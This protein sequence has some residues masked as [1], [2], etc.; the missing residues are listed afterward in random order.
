MSYELSVLADRPMAYWK[1]DGTSASGNLNWEQDINQLNRPLVDE[2]LAGGTSNPFTYGGGYGDTSNNVAYTQTST[3]VSGASASLL[4]RA[5]DLYDG[6]TYVIGRNEWFAKNP[7]NI[8]KGDQ[9][10]SSFS[11]EFW[12]SFNNMFQGSG[13][14]YNN[15]FD[16]NLKSNMTALEIISFTSL[17]DPHS[18]TQVNGTRLGSIYYDYTSNTFRF[19]VA[20]TDFNYFE[21]RDDA[22]FVV[23]NLNTP[24]H[25]VVTYDNGVLGITV[26]GE[27]GVAGKADISGCRTLSQWNSSGI[28]SAYKQRFF[29]GLI[30]I[31]NNLQ[32]YSYSYG[33]YVLAHLA[34]YD[35]VLPLDSIRRHIVWASHNDKPSIAP[36][37]IGT[38]M[39][40]TT[41]KA[42]NVLHHEN[43]MGSNF[44]DNYKIFNLN[45]DP[46]LGLT[47]KKIKSF[48]VNPSSDLS[49]SVYFSPP[50]QTVDHW[51]SPKDMHDTLYAN[52]N[53]SQGMKVSGYGSVVLDEFGSLISNKSPITI[54]CEVYPYSPA[55][56]NFL[57]AFTESISGN[58]IYAK[59]QSTGVYI[60]SY[61]YE[62]DTHTTLISSLFSVATA[63]AT[64]SPYDIGVSFGN[65]AVC[66]FVDGSSSSASTERIIINQS[67]MIEVGN[68]LQLSSGSANTYIRN[69]GFSNILYTDF[70][71]YNFGE[72]IM[73][74]ARFY[75]DLSISQIGYWIKRIPLASFGNRMVGSKVAWDGMDNCR[76]EYSDDDGYSWSILQKNSSIFY[77]VSYNYL[78]Y[79]YLLKVTIPYEYELGLVNQSFNNLEISFYENMGFST[80][81]H[82]YE[83][84]PKNDNILKPTFIVQR[85]SDQMFY[86]K[87]NFGIKFE[88]LG[89]IPIVNAGNEVTSY[90]S[91]I[92]SSSINAAYGIDFWVKFYSAPNAGSRILDSEPSTISPAV[93]LS[94]TTN[95]YDYS[96]GNYERF[97]SLDGFDNNINSV[98]INGQSVAPSGWTPRVNE[99]YHVTLDFGA[100]YTGSAL[101]LNGASVHS[102]ATYGYINMWNVPVSSSAAQI[103]YQSFIGNNITSIEDDATNLLMANPFS[104]STVS[105]AAFQI[106]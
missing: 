6:G 18:A 58:L 7:Y 55:T 31:R 87:N 14:D 65:G 56:P 61:S 104:A 103:R 13:Y 102:H 45:I 67:T 32:Y 33:S 39:F 62:T 98:Y 59:I 19:Q 72:N 71:G 92:A 85:N 100:A 82:K 29:D 53:I 66:L 57:W 38:S 79:D 30:W 17:N 47:G 16:V 46:D 24:Y 25:I 89:W 51:F 93:W 3:L 99:Y 63:S 52:S 81:D 27:A 41:E 9:A 90:A 75:Q 64:T 2:N 73:F 86:R 36:R 106:G 78:N 44:K 23:R 68:V 77:H 83:L 70:S 12:F 80:D 54:T 95:L 105:T 10:H 48:V 34:L 50:T 37:L 35:Y 91:I 22:Y 60:N 96:N 11:V 1:F 40:D 21:D 28:D 5:Q 43:I 74:M 49:S 84:L 101:Y 94:T 26:N 15:Y 97:A 69:F 4:V 76:V 8:L 42:Y 20:P 88:S